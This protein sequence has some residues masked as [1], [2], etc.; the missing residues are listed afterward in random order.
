MF[1]ACK[2]QSVYISA[3]LKQATY[4]TLT[5]MVFFVT[6]IIRKNSAFT[7]SPHC[8]MFKAIYLE[9]VQKYL[10]EGNK[11]VMDSKVR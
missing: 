2:D 8:S 9:Q 3:R 7:E 5:V 4:L 11:I 1:L 6:R 10:K